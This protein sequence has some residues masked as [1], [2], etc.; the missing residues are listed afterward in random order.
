MA[1]TSIRDKI[2]SSVVTKLSVI[3][4]PT[5]SQTVLQ[6]LEMADDLPQTPS[7]PVIY[8]AEGVEK[9]NSYD[10]ISFS[11][12]ELQIGI[13]YL[14]QDPSPTTQTKTARKMLEDV[15]KALQAEFMVLDSG[16]SNLSISLLEVS[17]MYEIEK[18]SGTVYVGMEWVAQYRHQTGDMTKG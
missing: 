10:C 4:K 13:I 7:L 14:A 1:D 5:Y 6:V 17:N 16:G 8:I 12:K 18:R 2:I 3:S 11:S 9:N 15:C